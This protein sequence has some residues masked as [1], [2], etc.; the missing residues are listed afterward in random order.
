MPRG[1]F[2]E[3]A[4]PSGT[5]ISILSWTDLP[6]L[7]GT[8]VQSTLL[9]PLLVIVTQ[10]VQVTVTWASATGASGAKT[11]A[12]GGMRNAMSKRRIFI[13]ELDP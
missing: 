3:Q 6:A 4:L 11:T 2:I 8:S 12:R 1:V 9:V 7:Q 5:C 10:N 13:C